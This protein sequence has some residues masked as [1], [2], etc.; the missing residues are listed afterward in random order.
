MKTIVIANFPRFSGEVFLPYL[1]ASAKTYYELNG[2]FNDEWQWHPCYLD[3]YST[4]H[5][6]TIKRE[7]LKAN[8]DVFAISLYV[9]NYKLAH[10][11][12]KWV[13]ETF[14]DCVII[15]GGPHQYFKHDMSWF[16]KHW[17]LDASLPGDCYGEL[18]FQEL[19]DNYNNGQVD[20]SMVTD[21]RYPTKK[22]KNISISKNTMSR[23]DKKLFQFNF[24]ALSIQL[25]PLKDFLIYQKDHFPKSISA[26][27][28]ETTR[29]CPYGCTYCDWGGGVG[30]TVIKKS[31]D[32]VYLD[33]DAAVQFNL[34]FL[35]IADANF[36]IFGERDVEII[37]YIVKCKIEMDQHFTI[38]Y[39]GFAKT[40]NRL[41]YIKEI[42]KV[43]VD[44]N[45][46]VTR[47]L[48]LSLQTLDEQILKNIDRVNINLDKQLEV[49]KPLA[50]DNQMPLY[51]EMIMGLPGIDLEK[52]YHELDILGKHN[53]S[54]Q[55]FEWILLPETPAYAYEYRNK[56]GLEVITKNNGWFSIEENSSM[57]EVVIGGMSFSKDEYLQMILSNSLYHLLVKG[58]FYT[59][60][61]EYI[62]STTSLGHGDIIRCIYDRFFMRSE[63][64]HNVLDRWHLIITDPDVPCTFDIKGNMVYGNLYFIALAFA[65]QQFVGQLVS[66]LQEEFKI[67][68]K[69]INKDRFITINS[70]NFGS[71][72]WQGAYR[73][74]FQRPAMSQNVYSVI[75]MFLNHIDTNAVFLAE[76][77]LLGII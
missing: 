63:Y 5:T 61:M 12:A 4:D 27:I 57:R 72:R 54:V 8:P 6:E 30:T 22:G 39:G 52:Y 36:G 65:D 67:P 77:K 32:N 11:I 13:K 23:D 60:A 73:Y 2:K 7:V 49:F 14:P 33:I 75:N 17:Y 62:L 55:W 70:L 43:D 34:S 1:W 48:K 29:G 47:E 3:C 76:K 44:N 50:K 38:G 24:S 28:L 58:G 35:Y 56:Y 10:D 37:N 21:A 71:A 25:E 9:W 45:L 53:L 15:S 46:S 69:I 66:W 40:E 59:N 68:Q 26:C 41:D 51:V 31:I 18:F 64:C 42:I 74:S 20:W 16:K 19:L